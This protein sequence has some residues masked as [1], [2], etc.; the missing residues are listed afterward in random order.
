MAAASVA[1][2]NLLHYTKPCCAIHHIPHA[3]ELYTVL[4]IITI[5]EIHFFILGTARFC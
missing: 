4:H 5:L 3:A 2:H 1:Y